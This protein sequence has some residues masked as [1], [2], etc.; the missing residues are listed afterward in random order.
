MADYEYGMVI[1]DITTPN[2][3]T[4]VTNLDTDCTHLEIE[5]TLAYIAGHGNLKVVDVSDPSH[6][7]ILGQTL[8]SSITL[9]DPSVANG[10]IY[11]ANHSGDDGELM[12][13]NASSPSNI[14]LVAE[15]DS[16]GTFQSFYIQNSLLYAV[17]YE[18]GLYLLN[19]SNPSYPVEITR[20]SEGH[21]WDV[22]LD[23]GLIY[24]V[25]TEGLQI[26]EIDYA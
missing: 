25:G 2:S 4:L 26:L 18:A 6:P 11:L 1:L 22:T 12:I 15:F 17:D 20:F 14:E 8:G 21:P 5:G 7:T 13:F 10:T 16:D 23:D 3:P 19:V 9:W 24:L